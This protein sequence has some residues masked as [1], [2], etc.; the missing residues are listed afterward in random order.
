MTFHVDRPRLL[1]LLQLFLH[2]LLSSF[3]RFQERISNISTIHIKDLSLERVALASN[4]T[5]S[6]VESFGTHFVK[7][8]REIQTLTVERFSFRD[9]NFFNSATQN[10]FGIYFADSLSNVE[11]V[12]ISNVAM[13]NVTS[14]GITKTEIFC[15][16]FKNSWINSTS[17]SFS[18]ISMTDISLNS[19]RQDSSA[20]VIQFERPLIGSNFSSSSSS[21]LVFQNISMRNIFGPTLGRVICIFFLN[22]VTNF[23]SIRL[24]DFFLTDFSV[25]ANSS[26]AQFYVARFNTNIIALS[27][28]SSS[29]SS[30]IF[31]DITCNNITAVAIGNS[32]SDFRALYFRANVAGFD[33]LLVRNIKTSSIKSF[34]TQSVNA[35]VPYFY[36]LRRLDSDF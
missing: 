28:S 1:L 17:I 30:F 35:L 21:S 4:F 2:V 5:S 20:L 26:A 31:E 22:D 36:V 11:Q 16:I 8:L 13:S 32:G 19:T 3:D 27:T 25:I 29:S 24:S 9:L 18:D 7:Q 33:S 10:F 34:A 15:S 23:T 12:S 6:A 14:F